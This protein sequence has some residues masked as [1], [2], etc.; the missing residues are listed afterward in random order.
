MC[1]YIAEEIVQE[2]SDRIIST[3]FP[4]IP[5]K[6]IYC[7]ANLRFSCTCLYQGDLAAVSK[8]FAQL[9][10]MSTFNKD[11][12]DNQG[13]LDGKGSDDYNPCTGSDI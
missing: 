7:T 12:D 6:S 3:G 4:R 5:N 1:F 11:Q 9:N 13:N 8:R 2:A 10:N